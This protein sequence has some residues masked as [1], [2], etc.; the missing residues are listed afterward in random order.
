MDEEGPLSRA[1]ARNARKERAARHIAKLQAR[2]RRL[3]GRA[4]ADKVIQEA[5]GPLLAMRPDLPPV[6]LE[7][8]V[9]QMRVRLTSAI[10]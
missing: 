7:A 6:E 10:S 4:A 1:R 9:D 8:F 2:M 3:D 5:I